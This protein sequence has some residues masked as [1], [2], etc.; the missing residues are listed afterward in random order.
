MLRINFL[1]IASIV[2]LTSS[3]S[4]TDLHPRANSAHDVELTQLEN[5]WQLT[6]T[7][8]DPYIITELDGSP[9]PQATVFEFE[10]VCAQRIR[11][12]MLYFGPPITERNR[13]DLPSIPHAEGWH[14]YSIDL[15]AHSSRPLPANTRLIRLDLG[16]DAG[17]TMRIRGIQLR[18]PNDREVAEQAAADA[19]RQAKQAV[20]IRIAANLTDPPSGRVESVVVGSN[21][22]L[23]RANLQGDESF[24]LVEFQIDRSIGDGVPA[25]M[26]DVITRRDGDVMQYEVP[27]YDDKRDRIHSGFA[28]AS[29]GD[30]AKL[31]TPRTFATEIKS[32]G[33]I[34]RVPPKPHNQKGLSG[35]SRRGPESDLDELGISAVTINL[36]LNRFVSE[37]PGPGH[38]RIPV[39]GADV[40]FDNSAFAGFDDWI[41]LARK[42]N[43][44]VSAIVLISNRNASAPT[45]PLAHRDASGGVYAMPDLTCERGAELY[46][47]VLDKIAARYCDP[48]SE[49][50]GITNWIAHN[51]VDFHSVWTNLGEQPREIATETYY[52]SMRMIHTAAR[53]YQ[54]GARVFASLTHHWVVPDDAAGD[55]LSPRE[56]IETLSRYSELEGDFAWGV[57]F[58]PYPE[59]LFAKNAW[60]DKSPID[61]FN[62]P[63]I[64]IQNLPVLTR[65]LE[66]PPLLDSRGNPRPVILSEQGFHTA[67]QSDEAQQAQAESLAY[68]MRQVAQLPLVES[69]HYHRWLDHPDEGGLNLGLRTAPSHGKPFGDKKQAWQVYC[70]FE[71]DGQD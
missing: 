44:V 52:R 56:V 28:L 40:Y 21:E 7:G 42:H 14:R 9:D 24:N 43:L 39:S 13:I 41:G 36:V 18:P 2:I 1:L 10:Y 61:D 33:T 5:A 47:Y 37:R 22:I 66:Q 30:K 53:R 51:E 48:G 29:I 16:T 8:T 46:A 38:Q 64:T 3:S 49:L 71:A 58:H 63:L 17:V 59:S 69:F 31:V 54:P 27:R 23:I 70:D 20:A 65:F 32:H 25:A 4:A 62:S 50:G 19:S 68:A 67:D 55:R 35:L 11:N 26:T 6:T 60:Q 34:P 45:S 57:A 15:A 12:P